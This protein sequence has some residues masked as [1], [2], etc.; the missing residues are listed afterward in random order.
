MPTN[1]YEILGLK[2]NASSRDIKK[3]YRKLAFAYHPD[4]NPGLPE[5]E[6]KF[7]EVS[8]AYQ[9]LSNDAERK[10]YDRS[11]ETGNLESFMEYWESQ[12]VKPRPPPPPAYYRRRYGKVE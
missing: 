8:T 12:D 7:I 5:V 4:R 6:K 11:L 10:R 9:I 2:K 3:A 1:Y